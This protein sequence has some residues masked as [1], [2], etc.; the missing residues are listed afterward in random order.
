M[1]RATWLLPRCSVVV[2]H[3]FLFLKKAPENKATQ[4]VRL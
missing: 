2:G 3:S 4:V 1:L